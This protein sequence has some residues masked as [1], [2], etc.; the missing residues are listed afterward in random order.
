MLKS[1]SWF[2]Q[3][4]GYELYL[5]GFDA[6]PFVK[7]RFL[8]ECP[9][10]M[11][12]EKNGRFDD[13]GEAQYQIT[14]HEGL[15]V[16]GGSFDEA[17][18]AIPDITYVLVCTGDDDRNILT[19]RKMRMLCEQNG[20]T[21]AIQAVIYDQ[22]KGE[23]LTRMKN[24]KKQTYD[25]TAIGGRE[26]T[27]CESMVYNSQWIEDALRRHNKWE[28]ATK[29]IEGFMRCR[30][31]QQSSVAAVIHREMKLRCQL[32][33]ILQKPEER[34]ENDREM[35]RRLEHRRWCAYIRSEGY[36]HG[37]DRN[38]L[39]KKHHLLVPYEQ[40]TESQRAQNDV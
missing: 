36:T 22:D 9:D 35:L 13:D 24:H 31:N 1:L 11:D 37:E 26:S 16:M 38:D 32:P 17:I 28:E 10:L 8:S 2:C 5:H 6:D 20:S 30:Y 3:M 14:I 21:P 39:A 12:K 27:Y 40:L 34:S 25:I 15:D 23:A 33:G 18:K 4:P 29:Q 7:E 19:A